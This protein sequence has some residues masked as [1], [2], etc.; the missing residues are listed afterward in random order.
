MP[1]NSSYHS[2]K[3]V[4]IATREVTVT[5]ETAISTAVV[6]IYCYQIIGMIFTGVKCKKQ[7]GISSVQSI[8]MNNSHMLLPP[9][10]WDL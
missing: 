9:M 3:T 4:A 5:I 8:F 6:M 10:L 7:E 2:N 1:Y